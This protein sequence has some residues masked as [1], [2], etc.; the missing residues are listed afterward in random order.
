MEPKF[1]ILL[2]IIACIIVSFLLVYFYSRRGT[3]PLALITAGVT[4]SLNFIL[5]V[6]I[7]YD[8]YY[9][10][11]EDA[12]DESIENILTIGYNIIYWSL[13][14]CSWI[15]V[16]LMQEYEDSGDFTKKKKFIRS[17]KNNLIFYGILG[18]IGIVL[19]IIS[20]FIY[21][22][23]EELILGNKKDKN[24]DPKDFSA[25]QAFILEIMNLSYL[26]GLFLFYFLFGYSIIT[27]PKK[28]FYKAKYDF[29][30][31]YLEW[32]V[33]DLKYNL[34]K[35][36]K[37]LVEDGYLLQ[38]TL[39]ELKV[40]KRVSLSKQFDEEDED[41]EKEKDQNK[42][43]E[44][45]NNKEEEASPF[46]SNNLSDY[47]NVMKERLDYLLENKE[48]FGIKLSRSSVDNTCEPLTSVSEL[49][50]LNR[51]I[52]KNEW[53]ILRI[54]IRIR[55]QYKHWLTL[56]T[57]LNL[58]NEENLTHIEITSKNEKEGLM[59]NDDKQNSDNNPEEGLIN[60]VE[61]PALDGDFIPMKNLSK[62]K[63]FYYLKLRRP[64]LYI[65][66]GILIFG[67]LLTIVSQIGAIADR[68]LYGYIL[69]ALIDGNLGILGLHFFIMI[70]IIFLFI[71]SIYTFFKL[72][73]SGYFYMYK[74]KQTD[75]VSLMYFSTNLCR[76]SFSICLDFIFNIDSQFK[77]NDD[78]YIPTQIQKILSFEVKDE[79]ESYF[80]KAYKYCP[81]ILV[82]YI[83]I[84]LFKIPQRIA[85]C[86]GKKIFSVESEESME[87]INEG[88]DYYME[89]N[90]KYKGDMIPKEKLVL[91][92]DKYNK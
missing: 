44:I 17:I 3:N 59:P 73:I 20:F 70:P 61:S 38:K 5:I 9:S 77:G 60:D 79:S 86:C 84:L 32:R 72:N 41:K 87:E 92:E 80:F 89:F 68:S 18:I 13:F 51:K 21:P 75:S 42:N 8:I 67:G 47:S 62:F 23:L 69:S 66:F 48:S 56:S 43:E 55:N 54:K 28:N 57:I 22:Y 46:S 27:L 12:H 37:E 34:E 65:Y 15:F 39:Q 50:K 11:K 19:G 58:E 30:I 52:N 35:L 2:E 25:F 10:Y 16:P 88:H 82:I 53:D 78:K 14:I 63:I 85:K 33:I 7:P 24:Q 26:I 76:I 49:I 45:N 36:Q 4:W 29:Q 83:I 91:P 71:L 81:L 90:Q 64:M 6:F 74:N 40:E 31:K 1:Y